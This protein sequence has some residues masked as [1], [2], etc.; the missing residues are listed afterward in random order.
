MASISKHA[1]IHRDI[2]PDNIMV[3]SICLTDKSSYDGE[4]DTSS[5]S[6][7]ELLQKWHLTLIDFG[8]ARA[9][10]PKDLASEES[11]KTRIKNIM[12]T[13]DLESIDHAIEDS[14]RGFFQSQEF[15]NEN[16]ASHH[17]VRA[18]SALGTQRFAAPEVKNKARLA[19]SSTDESS[20]KTTNT[21]LASS[22]SDYGMIADAFSVGA[23]ARFVLTG[24]PPH[25]SVDAFIANHKN[26]INKATR[27]IGRKLGKAKSKPKKTYRSGSNLPPEALRLVKG[28]MQ[29][30]ASMRTSVRDA[31][32]Y[33]YIYRVLGGNTP[34]KKEI[35]FLKCAQT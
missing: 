32:R 22:V 12:H 18:L 23:T 13:E 29:P 7:P 2:K 14:S 30:N 6:W 25:E 9:L 10:G 1:V 20:H 26:P 33:P 31:M 4:S 24:V 3:K 11:I 17:I 5:C 15:K 28:L 27:W 35:T 19:G 8:L 21:T 16:D 34:F